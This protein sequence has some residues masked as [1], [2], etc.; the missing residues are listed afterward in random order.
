MFEL[1]KQNDLWFQKWHKKFDEF[2]QKQLKVML[3]K[4]F[5]YNVFAEGMY[6]LDK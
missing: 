3:D 6:F 1:K 4:Y 5:A 2:S